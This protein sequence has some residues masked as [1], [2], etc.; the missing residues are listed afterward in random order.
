MNFYS[1]RA[2]TFIGLI[3]IAIGSGGVRPNLNAFGGTQYK[4]P[5][6]GN[7]LK[8]FFSLQFFLMKCGSLF[9]YF[10]APTL[11]GDVE[12]F[13]MD[14]CYPLAFGVPA[15]ALFLSFVI[16][17]CGTRLYIRTPPSG[18][19]LVKVLACIF[20]RHSSLNLKTMQSLL[21]HFRMH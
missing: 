7:E 6:Q 17:M 4:L 9:A 3:I 18:N 14:D 21:I 15:I 12:C 1:N 10:V 11:R 5:E 8:I 13:G 2:L 16:F 20:V 19:M